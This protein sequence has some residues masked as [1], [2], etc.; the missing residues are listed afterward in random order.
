MTIYKLKMYTHKNDGS[1]KAKIKM[2]RQL[3]ERI[4]RNWELL[5]VERED[6]RQSRLKVD[7]AAMNQI[8]SES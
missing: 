2:E 8:G 6:Q 3:W 7:R 1:E 5:I 4:Y